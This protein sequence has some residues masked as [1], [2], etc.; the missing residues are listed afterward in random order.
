MMTDN[1]II[2]R[3]YGR[4]CKYSLWLVAAAALITLLIMNVCEIGGL[5]SFLVICIV[6][7]LI[8][9]GAY[10]VAW[11][12]VAKSSSSVLTKFYLAASALRMLTAVLVVVA[13]CLLNNDA[14]QIRNFV[15]LFSSFYVVMLIFD[16]IFFARVE[17]KNNH[18][19]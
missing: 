6:Y 16:G 5:I 14:T 12:G 3:A 10:G 4:Y 18:K 9:N 1:K 13:F 7:T 17:K 11:K 15:I 8:A 2:S 19:E